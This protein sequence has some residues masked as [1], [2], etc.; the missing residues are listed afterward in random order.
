MFNSPEKVSSL[1]TA[2]VIKH[3]ARISECWQKMV[4][5]HCDGTQDRAMYRHIKQKML[6][7]EITIC[8]SFD[9][10]YRQTVQ[11]GSD[12]QGF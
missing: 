12:W 7:S 1:Y 10:A 8:Q 4:I 11:Q 5:H 9:A 6:I 2:I 3:Y